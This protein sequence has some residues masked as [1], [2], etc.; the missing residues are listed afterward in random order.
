MKIGYTLMT[1]Q[2][3]PTDLVRY[4]VAAEQAGFAFEVSSDHYFPWL[5]EQGHSPNAWTVLGAVAHATHRVELITYVTC[6]TMRYHP[7]VV[8]QQAATMG[9]L[10]S[11]RF[12]LGL[13]SGENLNEHVVGLGWPSVTVRHEMLVEALQIIKA[14][15]EGGYVTRRGPYYQVDSAKLWDLPTRRVPIAVAVSG[16]R[17]CELFAP[18]ADHMIAAE[19]TAELGVMWDAARPGNG[20]SRRIGQLP[21]CFDADPQAAA[22]RAHEQFRWMAGGW[23][24]NAELPS[25]AGFAAASQFAR[26][27]DIAKLISCGPDVTAHVAAARPF[28]EAGFTDLALVQIGGAPRHQEPFFD[29]A[30]DKLLPALR[31]EF[32]AG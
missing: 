3:G 26:P 8:A 29:Y 4:A 7:A 24:V 15:F 19:P 22:T 17:S 1:E 5:D 14:L 32:D 31:A 28:A 30:R 9:L 13:G 25:T 18:L 20:P 21:I 12:I 11:N 27:D 6:P 2:S 10:S 23:E 16:R